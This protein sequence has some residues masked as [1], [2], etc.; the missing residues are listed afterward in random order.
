L[1][2][3]TVIAARQGIGCVVVFALCE[4]RSLGSLKGE[5]KMI[6]TASALIMAALAGTAIAQPGNVN[7]AYIFGDGTN[8]VYQVTL[9][10]V[11][12]LNPRTAN[13]H[14]AISSDVQ[15][16]NPYRA[17]WGGSSNNF[18]IGGFGGLTEI[19][20]NTGAF[21]KQIGSGAS[22]DVQI[23]YTGNTLYRGSGAGIDEHDIATGAYIRTLTGGVGA[24][25]FHLMKS[26]GTD[27]Y[28]S[29]WNTGGATQV[30][31]VDQ[32]T[33]NTTAVLGNTPFGCQAL[34]FD[35]LG[36]LYASGLYESAAVSGV[37]KYDFGTGTWNMFAT[38]TSAGGGGYPNGPHGFTFGTDGDLYMAFASGTVEVFDG[39]TGAFLRRLWQ[40]NDKLTDIQFKPVPTPGALALAGIAA[41]A[42]RR[43]RR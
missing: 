21:V 32:I 31:K 37:W 1:D 41:L 29:R 30:I 7:D 9:G 23:S 11:E 42:G 40:V 6:R 8:Q 34:E 43:R 4:D 3:G 38:A 15:P 5:K 14:F 20:G 12:V 17:T 28:V 27:L 10:G 25:G 36:N 26:R 2:R 13:S 16:I 35:S 24:G 22:L 19:D 18:F 39:Q 33:G